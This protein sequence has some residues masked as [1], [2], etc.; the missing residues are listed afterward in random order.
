MKNNI[1]F[2]MDG[3]ND[4]EIG[5]GQNDVSGS[6]QA[7][8]NVEPRNMVFEPVSKP[9]ET[10]LRYTRPQVRCCVTTLTDSREITWTYRTWRTYTDK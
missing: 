2:D 1:I 9:D 3:V 6:L 4:G 7:A 5:C 10:L 8:F